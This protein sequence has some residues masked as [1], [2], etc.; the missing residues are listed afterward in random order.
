MCPILIDLALNRGHRSGRGVGG[1]RGR[2][3]A[4]VQPQQ[5]CKQ[6]SSSHA[7]INLLAEQDLLH[8]LIP[9]TFMGIND[10]GKYFCSQVKL[11]WPTPCIEATDVLRSNAP[12]KLTRFC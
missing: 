10:C 6:Q 7:V 11:A 12:V 9:Q 3:G 2:S 8:Y 1:G 5:E 4:G